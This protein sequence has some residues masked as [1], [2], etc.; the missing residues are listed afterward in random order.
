MPDNS[1]IL[2]DRC[3]VKSADKRQ[4]P[5]YHVT[6]DFFLL[7]P[8]GMFL[9]VYI[10]KYAFALSFQVMKNLYLSCFLTTLLTLTALVR[11][12]RYNSIWLNLTAMLK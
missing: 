3:I 4:S 10:V 9:S 6:Y 5:D 12:S 1:K 7:E 8:T 2:L 11:A